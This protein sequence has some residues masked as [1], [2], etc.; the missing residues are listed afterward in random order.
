MSDNLQLHI[1]AVIIYAKQI[2]SKSNKSKLHIHFK[3][4]H[5]CDEPRNIP[6]PIKHLTPN[7]SISLARN[8]LEWKP[9]AS[10]REISITPF[11]SSTKHQRAHGNMVARAEGLH[12]RRINSAKR[13]GRRITLGAALAPLILA[14]P[15][16][17]SLFILLDVP[18]FFNLLI[19]HRPRAFLFYTRV[20][21]G[22]NEARGYWRSYRGENCVVRIGLIMVLTFFTR[23][24]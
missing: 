5:P 22:I 24:Y 9:A 13:R 6:K 12:G 17:R 4:W 7:S 1:N 21:A 20:E 14:L 10:K 11:H 2:I 18:W 3:F 15:R 23:E 19:F 8:E 16:A